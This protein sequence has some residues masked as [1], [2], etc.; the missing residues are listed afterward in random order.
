MD[1]LRYNDKV[2]C[3][4]LIL[5]ICKNPVPQIGYKYLIDIVLNLLF[6]SHNINP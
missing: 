6:L 2:L 5:I 1:F 3:D 4:Y